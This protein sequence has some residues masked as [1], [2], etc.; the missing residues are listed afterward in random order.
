M[1]LI[2]YLLCFLVL[3]QQYI[4]KS[5]QYFPN[6]NNSCAF[7]LLKLRRRTLEL[8][9]YTA[10]G[11]QL[12]VPN[13]IREKVRQRKNAPLVNLLFKNISLF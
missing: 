9:A 4:Y 7:S 12:P 10:K 13:L 11:L 6:L 5:I 8:Y 3:L 1:C 2:I